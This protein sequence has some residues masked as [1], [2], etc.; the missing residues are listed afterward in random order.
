MPGDFT[1]TREG[2]CVCS[3]LLFSGGAKE[4]E[5]REVADNII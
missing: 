2:I 4:V 5:P 3:D 1:K